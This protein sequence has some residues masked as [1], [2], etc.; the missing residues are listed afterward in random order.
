VHDDRVVLVNE[1]RAQW[2]VEVVEVA[3]NIEDIDRPGSGRDKVGPL[4]LGRGLREGVAGAEHNAVVPPKFAQQR[5]QGDDRAN[6]AAA[7]AAAFSA[8]QARASV[9]NSS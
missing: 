7:V 3:D 2:R 1:H 9:M 6:A 8:G 5:G 4:Q